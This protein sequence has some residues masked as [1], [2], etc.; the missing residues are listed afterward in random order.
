MPLI[1]CLSES[2]YVQLV[3]LVG[4]LNVVLYLILM[5]TKGEENLC[6]RKARG[7]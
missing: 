5:T 6:M 2:R 4:L 7:Y 3:C 1:Y